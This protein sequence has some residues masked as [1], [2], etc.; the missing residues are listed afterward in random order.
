MG[1]VS[2]ILK[3]LI[4][5][6]A[7]SAILAG[8]AGV[9]L[10]NANCARVEPVQAV[11]D[12]SVTASIDYADINRILLMTDD[13]ARRHALE[14][15]IDALSGN[16]ASEAAAMTARLRIA[17]AHSEL[18]LHHYDAAAATLKPVAL[19][20]PYA[21]PALLL[22]VA[23]KQQQGKPEDAAKW[24]L[25]LPEFFP[26]RKEAIQG[27]LLAAEAQSDAQRKIALLTQARRLAEAGRQRAEALYRAA[28]DANFIQAT[29]SEQVSSAFWLLAQE[30]L[31][32]PAFIQAETDQLQA[33]RHIECLKS[34]LVGMHTQREKHP[35]LLSDLD[36][37]L[38]WLETQLPQEKSGLSIQEQRFLALAAELKGCRA[39]KQDC[40]ALQARHRVS[41][42]EL[43][44]LRNRLRNLEQQRDFLARQKQAL[45]VRWRAEQQNMATLGQSLMQ[46]NSAG[47]EVM[48]RLLQQ[49]L[50]K[51][52]SEWQALTADAYLQLAS[53][54]DPRLHERRQEQEKNQD[55]RM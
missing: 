48:Q 35:T 31:T 45:A 32:D 16:T 30:A 13:K 28:A 29:A 26:E 36:A 51:S 27:L 6:V 14:K 34:H 11:P 8:I 49:A 23:V 33:R 2:V 15:Q 42:Q 40:S 25:H 47:R 18:R 53:A 39:G 55:S 19:D 3:R 21:A 10:A 41:G 1:S 37:T 43:T 7:L 52:R 54:Q 4:G 17:L 9:A 22:L 44:R 46:Q 24:A 5:H 50:E 12:K 38:H 20:N